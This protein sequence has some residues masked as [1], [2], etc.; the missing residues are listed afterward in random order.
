[1][2]KVLFFNVKSQSENVLSKTQLLTLKH[3]NDVVGDMFSVPYSSN[4]QVWN[5]DVAS[6]VWQQKPAYINKN[7]NCASILTKKKLNLLIK[8]CSWRSEEG[9]TLRRASHET[10]K[11]DIFV[12][13]E[14]MIKSKVC[15]L[16]NA[17]CFL[18]RTMKSV[19]NS[20]R[21]RF[22]RSKDP[23]TMFKYKVFVR[24]LCRKFH[25]SCRRHSRVYHDI[26]SSACC[27]WWINNPEIGQTV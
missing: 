3:P 25:W 11:H 5:C 26:P 6:F 23:R 9:R 16:K 1:M 15:L 14:G 4:K 2:F 13:D 18:E 27:I 8:K 19:Q 22:R 7:H 10:F 17:K 24:F 20:F 21:I 12:F